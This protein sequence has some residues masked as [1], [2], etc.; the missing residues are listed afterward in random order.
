[1]TNAT[2]PFRAVFEMQRQSTRSGHRLFQQ[3]L[4]VQQ[5]AL[6]R[7]AGNSLAAQRAAQ[8][9]GVELAREATNAQ[10][11]AFRSAFGAADARGP[12]T[13]DE[14]F[15]AVADAQDEA[16]DELESEFHAVLEDLGEQQRA[17]LAQSFEAFLEAHRDV[18]RQ[19]M[20]NLRQAQE[21]AVATQRRTGAVTRSAAESAED[22]VDEAADAAAEGTEA[23]AESIDALADLGGTYADRLYEEGYESVDALAEAEA[24][25]VAEAVDVSEAQAEEW[26]EG[27][28]SG[29]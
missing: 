18:E 11:E 12:S 16:W 17:A 6:E 22:V 15:R 26:I 19:T 3:G 10:V 1:M 28:R 5:D 7:F 20:A 24:D 2:T 14:Q 25:A 4:E 29:T 21:A 23:A 8:R 9:Q 27:A 13:V